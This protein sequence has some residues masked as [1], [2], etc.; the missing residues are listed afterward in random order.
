MNLKNLNLR[1]EQPHL[2]QRILA[3]SILLIFTGIPLLFAPTEATPTANISVM[4]ELLHLKY[5]GIIFITI[6]V[7]LFAGSFNHKNNYQIVRIV[8]SVALGFMIMW[9][10]S[11]LYGGLT[12][13]VTG[14]AITSYQAFITYIIYNTLKDPGFQI[15]NLIRKVRNGNDA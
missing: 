15:S 1:K 8:L 9:L 11:L 6:G 12:G 14:L 2:W 7:A 4:S 5:H 3:I 13:K 10:L